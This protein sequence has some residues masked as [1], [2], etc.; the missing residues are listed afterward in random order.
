[1]STI[2][3][4]FVADARAV[5][6][7]DACDRLKVPKPKKGKPE[8]EGPCPRC[9]GNDRFAVNRGKGVWNCRGCGAGGRDG[10]GLAAHMH[11]LDLGRRAEFLEACSIALD[12]A[13]PK[14]DECETDEEKAAREARIAASKAKAEADRLENQRK[15]NDFRQL[16]INR[17]R[18]LWLNAV[19]C[20]LD[21]PV[22]QTGKHLISA[23]VKARTGFEPLE[24][25]FQNI[26]F[27][28]SATYWHGTDEMGRPFPLYV[29]PAL[30]A[31]F[32][33]RD[34]H[35]VGSQT[36]W[37]DLDV[38]PKRRP[39][40]FGVT[41]VG[42]EAGFGERS[43]GKQTGI[44]PEWIEAGFYEPLSSKKMRGAKKGGVMPIAGNPYSARWMGGEGIETTW[45][46]A[47]PDGCRDDTFYFAAGDIGNMAGPADPK[48]AFDHTTLRKEDSAGRL[49]KVKVQGPIP[50]PDSEGEAIWI[51]DHVIDLI[52]LADGD[53]EPV[54]TASAMARAVARHGREGREV[55]PLWPPEGTDFAD[56]IASVLE[57]AAYA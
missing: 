1:M 17:A 3:D 12:Q 8:H 6:F 25:V 41:K 33:D 38:V 4:L 16:E 30:V 7:A 35:I 49:R 48:S 55:M 45:A 24:S 52:L 56:A 9:G 37:I 28:P 46:I 11:Q 15:Q 18:G 53:S 34:H 5:S 14:E 2:I 43:Q 47:A 20:R 22:A 44:K 27:I 23:Y 32:V 10:I 50:K 29:G 36:I 40:L 21:N 13:I 54:A 57:G 39:M 19:D 42:R 26:R 51:P 31:P